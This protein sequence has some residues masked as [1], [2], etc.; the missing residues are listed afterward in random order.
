MSVK[1]KEGTKADTAIETA[2]AKDS[3]MTRKEFLEL[4][5]GRKCGLIMCSSCWW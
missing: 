3:A 5:R 2:G 1:C 4:F